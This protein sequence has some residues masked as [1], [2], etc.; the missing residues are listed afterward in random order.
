LSTKTE[1]TNIK[2]RVESNQKYANKIKFKHKQNLEKAS[3]IKNYLNQNGCYVPFSQKE[4]KNQ[5]SEFLVDKDTGELKDF[6]ALYNTYYDLQKPL[7]AVLAEF[8]EDRKKGYQILMSQYSRNKIDSIHNYKKSKTARRVW[9][10]FL[11]SRPELIRDY[12]PMHLTLTVPHPDGKWRGQSFFSKEL[13]KEFNLMRK[14]KAFQGFVFGGAYNVETTN[15]KAGNGNH[16]HLHAL[17]FQKQGYE[18]EEV[19]QWIKK[20]WSARTGAMEQFVKYQNLYVHQKDESGRWKVE[21]LPEQTYLETDANGEEREVLVKPERH[22]KKRFE[23][24]NENE[25]YQNLSDQEKIEQMSI[26]I[27]ETLKYHFKEDAFK[28]KNGNYDV[29]FIHEIL[30][31]GKGLR[32]YSK[33]GAFYGVEELNISTRNK[34]KD[35]EDEE[36]N[37]D[38]N[39]NLK[40]TYN[41]ISLEEANWLDVKLKL[42]PVEDLRFLVNPEKKEYKLFPNSKDMLTIR[43]EFTLKK[44]AAALAKNQFSKLTLAVDKKKAVKKLQVL[45]TAT[46]FEI[47]DMSSLSAK[48]FEYPKTDAL[49]YWYKHEKIRSEKGLQK[50]EI[51]ELDILTLNGYK[52]AEAIPIKARKEI[53]AIKR[54][55][56]NIKPCAYNNFDSINRLSDIDLLNETVRLIDQFESQ[57]A[58]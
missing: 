45:K 5:K 1:N 7:R 23:L 31:E 54:K 9:I 3:A 42:V 20:E 43:P 19:E 25:W 58:S 56:F 24:T 32:F 28:D 8:K 40:N 46:G 6:E 34:D 37:T 18:K 2:S 53:V 55:P 39:E 41:P 38:V 27:L 49:G 22:I 21:T 17:I 50:I 11:K 48:V 47:Y 26:G 13:V 30:K 4:Y 12:L 16:T 52:P 35:P 36:L 44:I 15:S 51:R 14:N 29:E 33:F 10:E 57:K